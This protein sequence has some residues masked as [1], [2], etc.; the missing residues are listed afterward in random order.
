[1]YSRS[2]FSLV[3][4]CNQKTISSDNVCFWLFFQSKHLTLL[5]E[6]LSVSCVA[7]YASLIHHPLI[8]FRMY[9]CTV[10]L[11]S[12]SLLFST[13]QWFVDEWKDWWCRCSLGALTVYWWKRHWYTC[14]VGVRSC[15]IIYAFRLTPSY[16][17]PPRQYGTLLA[18]RFWCVCATE[19]SSV[20]F[21]S[22]LI[23]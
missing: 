7:G 10:E 3:H 23:G 20:P 17:P 4:W 8:F 2:W 22:C 21:F 11:F 16:S 18:K 15:T 19:S 9:N 13:F 12:P 5:C 1:M 14:T 6:V